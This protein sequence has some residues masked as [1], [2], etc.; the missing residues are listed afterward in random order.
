MEGWHPEVHFGT[1]EALHLAVR[2]STRTLRE[3]PHCEQR[4]PDLSFRKAPASRSRGLGRGT[5]IGR[6]ETAPQRLAPPAPQ[7]GRV[8]ISS[9][10]STGG[11]G[12][13]ETQALHRHRS[14]LEVR[15][16]LAAQSPL[17][18]FGDWGRGGAGYCPHGI[19]F[20]SLLSLCPGLGE[21]CAPQAPGGSRA[22]GRGGGAGAAGLEPCGRLP[23]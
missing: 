8:D 12:K 19:Y 5:F 7:P 23:G 13:P 17:F 3:T 14:G 2:L 10:R 4:F 6:R 16:I 15:G 11:L 21:A 22:G 18:L 20:L 9:G 1:A